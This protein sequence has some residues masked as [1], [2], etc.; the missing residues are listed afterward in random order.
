MIEFQIESVYNIK[1]KGVV[2]VIVVS[3]GIIEKGFTFSIENKKFT[4]K[5][6][7]MHSRTVNKIEEGNR[8]E[9]YLDKPDYE[10]LKKYK[11][12]SIKIIGEKTEISDE[13]K[14]PK[15][16]ETISKNEKE[17]MDKK[18]WNKIDEHAWHI[19]AKGFMLYIIISTIIAPFLGIIMFFVLN[20]LYK[21]EKKIYLHIGLGFALFVNVSSII[22]AITYSHPYKSLEFF[23]IYW[24]YIFDMIGNLF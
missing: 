22:I 8:A 4:I 15:I 14:Y 12:K 5:S 3:S 24:K 13:F 17:S 2:P 21:G 7:Q 20:K 18:N 9:I 10:L 11:G 16:K 1:N 6:I 19:G 23:G